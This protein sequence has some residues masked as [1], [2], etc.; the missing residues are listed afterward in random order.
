M[1]QKTFYYGYGQVGGASTWSQLAIF[2]DKPAAEAW[3]AA[4]V[5]DY[6]QHVVVLELTG[7]AVS[8]LT[9]VPPGP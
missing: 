8:D 4:T 5:N 6:F 7:E 2:T 9:Y 1:A 3:A